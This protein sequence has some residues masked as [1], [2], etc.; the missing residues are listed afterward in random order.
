[1]IG[2]Q[3][4][5][6]K[7]VLGFSIALTESA[8]VWIEILQD[9]KDRDLEEVLL[10]VI[11]ALSGIHDSIYSIY[12]SYNFDNVAFIFLE[13]LPI[14]FVLVTEKKSVMILN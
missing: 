11:N 9:L 1:M 10:V 8:Y 7:E 6:T 13:I 4:A 14:K 5:G 12:S 3:L 2:I